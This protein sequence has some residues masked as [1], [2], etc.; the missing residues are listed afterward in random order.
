[1]TSQDAVEAGGRLRRA[2]RRLGS[3]QQDLEDRDLQRDVATTTGCM[4]VADAVDRDRVALTGTLRHVTL[5]PR[6]GTP[7]L[8]A[9]LYDGSGSVTIVWLGRRRIAGIQ[10]GA[11]LVVHGRI[12]T[13]GGEQIMYNPR[14]ELRG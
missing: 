9:E 5:R 7:A 6:S 2:L 13:T 11:A 12:S 10:P 4:R 3:S 1:M 8:E 14:Y